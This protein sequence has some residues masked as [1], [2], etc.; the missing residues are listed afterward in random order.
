MPQVD[1]NL[2]LVAE[3]CFETEEWI[4]NSNGVLC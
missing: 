1:F 3:H 2:L 4:S